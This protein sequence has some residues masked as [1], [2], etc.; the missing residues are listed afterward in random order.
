MSGSP[1]SSFQLPERG[2]R[3]KVFAAVH[4]QSTFSNDD[5]NAY[6]FR[7][8]PGEDAPKLDST[9]LHVP[10]LCV[11]GDFKGRGGPDFEC[12]DPHIDVG[13]PSSS[14]GWT[15]LN[16][17][18]DA[19]G[20]DDVVA[21]TYGLPFNVLHGFYVHY[22]ENGR[23]VTPLS[24]VPVVGGDFDGDGRR[25]V[26]GYDIPNERVFVG[27]S[28][29][30]ADL[31]SGVRDESAAM[32]SEVVTYT[33]QWSATPV[34][35]K[36]CVH[37]QRCIRHGLTVVQKHAVNTGA[38]FVETG[39]NYD[40]PRYD[41]FGRGFLG[42]GTVREW[43]SERPSEMITTYDNVTSNKG[44][45]LA[46]LPKSVRRYVP[47]D[48]ELKGAGT[49]SVK[50]RAS[51]VT[52]EYAIDFSGKSF[53]RHPTSWESA[54]WEPSAKLDWTPTIAEHFGAFAPSPILRKR[55]GS[56]AYDAYGNETSA[57]ASTLNGD[58]V[59]TTTTY[60]N[61]VA[62]WLIGL[63]RTV[64]TSESAPPGA[65]KNRKVEYVYDPFGRVQNVFFEQGDADPEIPEKLTYEYNAD[66]LPI[67][68]TAT[69]AGEPPRHTYTQY[70][71]EEG[72]FR[73]KV[74][75]DLGHTARMLAHP[76]FGAPSNTLDPN[77]VSAKT[78]FDEFGRVRRT[79]RSGGPTVYIDLNARLDT[80]GNLIGST[81]DTHG[82]GVVSAYAE[83]DTAG[84]KVLA[85]HIGFDG[86]PI[87]QVVQ[88]DRLGRVVFESRPGFGS[89]DSKGTSYRYDSLDRK[90]FTTLPDGTLPI[91]EAPVFF[92]NS[93][94]DGEGHE[95]YVVRDVEGR[96]SSSV[97]VNGGQNLATTF[98]YGDFHQL[99]ATTDPLNHVTSISYDKRGRRKQIVDPDTGISTTHYNGFGEVTSVE[100]PSVNS[101]PVPALARFTHDVLGR[102]TQLDNVDGAAQSTTKFTWDT[103]LNGIGL[104]ATSESPDHVLRGFDYDSA[105]R[106]WKDTWQVN[107][108]PFEVL[109]TYDSSGRMATQ[110]YPNVPARSTRFTVK[111]AYTASTGYELS[112]SEVDLPVASTF[113][114]VNARNADDQLVDGS[115]GNGLVTHR[116]Y[117]PST[118]RLWTIA[119]GPPNCGPGCVVPLYSLMYAYHTDGQ[120]SERVDSL[121]SRSESFTYDSAHRLVGW[122]LTNPGAMRDTTYTYDEIGNLKTVSL[123]NVV[124]ETN[125]YECHD[126]LCAGPH[127]LMASNIAG[128]K[129]T[130][131][132]DARGRQSTTPTRTVVFTERNLPHSIGN[133]QF[134]YDAG[135]TRVKK[136]DSTGE[137]ISIGGIYERR[138]N[139]AS[140]QHVFYVAGTDGTMTQVVYDQPTNTDHVEYLH[141]DALGT[142]GAVSNQAGI[143]T[144]H[145]HEPFG[146]SILPNGLPTA[147][148]TGDVRFGFTGHMSD[149]ALGLVNM[150]GRIY[151]PA[152]RHFITPDPLIPNA[153]NTQSYNRYSYVEN[154]P[155]NRTDPS[156]F[157]SDDGNPFVPLVDMAP[158]IFGSFFNNAIIKASVNFSAPGIPLHFPAA[159]K[160]Q[161][162]VM[163]APSGHV[164]YVPV[165]PPAIV[166][167]YSFE[168]TEAAPVQDLIITTFTPPP[169]R[170]FA[171][172]KQ[173]V[174]YYIGNDA[175]NAIADNYEAVRPSEYIYTNSIPVVTIAK[176]LRGNLDLLR[177]ADLLLR[178]D[179]FNATTHEIYEIKPSGSEAA[180]RLQLLGYI[181]ALA[182]AGIPAMPGGSGPGTAGTL[183][184]PGG[185]YQ[186]WTPDPG[187]I[188]Y[189][190]VTTRSPLWGLDP[191]YWAVG[192]GAAV[193]VVIVATPVLIGIAPAAAPEA[194]A[195]VGGLLPAF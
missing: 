13:F 27:S 61:R 147:A 45:Y 39:Y 186:Y 11:L 6:G 16:F 34:V 71:P 7:L 101:S 109:T 108:E 127:A 122:K 56:Y 152:Q 63:P 62:D 177:N 132:Y 58:T 51:L 66:G 90:L 86:T 5:S 96:I 95:R 192:G 49:E 156:G 79:A 118:G 50:V 89:P 31:L 188:S 146:A 26:Y 133:A 189:K 68:L 175:H 182:R 155:I 144:L 131:G 158:V 180:A 20:R 47:V 129:S 194:A 40:D 125:V 130:F 111:R 149:D 80:Q 136:N 8:A 148:P 48:P 169:I 60:E 121:R 126:S 161:T 176:D 44:V 93:T 30:T 140:V 88:Y 72:I 135:G 78:T 104:P 84:H 85:Q 153:L 57:D 145:D 103:G 67:S 164:A 100:S 191:V 190:W 187:I 91:I 151:D 15:V 98:T 81:I 28:L 120:V 174:R 94:V 22:D 128:T 171:P 23:Q 119:D 59:V 173:P 9:G 42:F 70:D 142:T 77:G 76:V 18:V 113:W 138:T 82:N 14:A 92:G 37:P 165:A 54:E 168:N 154:D 172:G 160:F 52:F 64:L 21:Y 35:A 134:L 150:K 181:S 2:G 29:P 107:G 141:R 65:L 97:Q 170:A 10:P 195:G 38:G 123:N 43:S 24:R 157:F 4:Y 1:F 166:P 53:L 25:D 36:A 102:V 163:P 105:G 17:D 106:P 33:Q 74:W 99:V 46:F 110:V 3:A 116:N 12:F 117:Y 32:T 184:A 55:S 112:A 73:R 87:V 19:D 139:G 69:A 178:P 185:Y 83:L 167:L 159:R 41:V 115:F 193:A 124:T 114:T 75:N 137:T 162:P 183:S 143:M 179:I